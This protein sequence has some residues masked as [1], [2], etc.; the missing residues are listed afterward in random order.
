MRTRPADIAEKQSSRHYKTLGIG[1][2][3]P[4]L[5]VIGVIGLL[6]FFQDELYGNVSWFRDPFTVLIVGLFAFGQF[7][8]LKQFFAWFSNAGKVNKLVSAIAQARDLDKLSDLV[9]LGEKIRATV[10]HSDTRSLV[11]NWLDY[12]G[13]S[14]EKRN[15][16]LENNSYVRMDLTKEKISYFHVLMN[17]VT[18]K[19]GFVGTLIGLMMTF[20]AMKRAI[21][22]LPES[23][24]E[25]T[26]VTDICRAIDGDQFAILTTLVAT[27]LSLLAEFMTIQMINRFSVN[28]EMIM[29]YLTDWY[30]TRVEPLYSHG[31]NDSV[32]RI[33]SSF[34]RAEE[35]LAQNMQV[36]TSLAK[37]NAEQLASLSDFHATIE[38]RV[39]ELESYETHYRSLLST[40]NEAEQHLAGN[41]RI[42]TDVAKK[43]GEQL[44]GMVS[45]QEIIGARVENLHFYEEQY[46]ILKS[47]SDES[48]E[49]K[50]P[51][52]NGGAR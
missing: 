12:R 18:L 46:R 7:L 9:A 19:L 31:A 51:I 47:S 20:P 43:T 2:F 27:V 49:S 34:S 36:L 5:L 38:K 11:L 32:G 28:E 14:T 22:A 26:F 50:T 40:K 29:S 13:D 25:M 4:I 8:A 30:H 41:I 37:K 6:F 16:V 15:D 42:L 45:S 24:G 10:P 21:Q 44:K 48:S 17:R 35:L 52:S 23:G 3:V 39:S 33:E 1:I